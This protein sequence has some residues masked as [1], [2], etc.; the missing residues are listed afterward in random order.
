MT[1]SIQKFTDVTYWKEV[2]SSS[3]QGLNTVDLRKFHFQRFDN[4]LRKHLP[5]KAGL[6]LL[7]IG[8]AYSGWLEYFYREFHYQ[9]FGIDYSA[10]DVT[11]TNKL[12]ETLGIPCTVEHR[13]L[14]GDNDEYFSRFDLIF[15]FGVVEHFDRPEEPL[16]ICS[17]FLGDGG[18]IITI[19]PNTVGL[20]FA[21]QKYLDRKVF[22]L[23]LPITKKDLE[24]FHHRAGFETILCQ[25]IGSFHPGILNYSNKSRLVRKLLHL[26]LGLIVNGSQ[27][28][29][30]R[31][32]W[33]P[34]SEALSPFTIFIG[35]KVV[36]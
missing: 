4:V 2:W 8:S 23:H 10:A 11:K 19:I 34:E 14:F 31:L 3:Q 36:Q 20:L 1:I 12:L 32:R 5:P 18:R 22:N 30:S 27:L 26:T 7:E 35:K 9:V 16:R 33:H 28:V 29:F 25:H 17:T 24:S 13:D 6:K 21:V 15:S